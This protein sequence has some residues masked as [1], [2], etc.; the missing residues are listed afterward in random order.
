[1][2]PKQ[3]SSL[4]PSPLNE[5]PR[6]PESRNCADTL[7]AISILLRNAFSTADFQIFA[8]ENI[9]QQKDPTTKPPRK[10]SDNNR[11]SLR[12]NGAANNFSHLENAEKHVLLNGASHASS[13]LCVSRDDRIKSSTAPLCHLPRHRLLVWSGF[14]LQIFAYRIELNR[15]NSSRAS[16]FPRIIEPR[17]LRVLS[18]I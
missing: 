14:P 10:V 9:F 2:L 16:R 12:E 1:M 6:F 15:I 18:F 11:N 8:N 4:Y 3:C 17:T 7:P 13:L 5:V